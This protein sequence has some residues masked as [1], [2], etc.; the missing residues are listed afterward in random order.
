[1]A[2]TE[3]IRQKVEDSQNVKYKVPPKKAI[4]QGDIAEPKNIV[5]F[6][7]AALTGLLSNSNVKVHDGLFNEKAIVDKAYKIAKLMQDK[8]LEN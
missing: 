1:M 2:T 7:S 6:A 8:E 5:E 3:E 4:I